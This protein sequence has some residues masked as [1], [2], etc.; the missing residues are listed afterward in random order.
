M[1]LPF[2][3]WSD[4]YE[5]TEKN[6]VKT[7]HAFQQEN[8][9]FMK[10]VSESGTR[11][12]IDRKEK[13][14]QKSYEAN[15]PIQTI[16]IPSHGPSKVLVEFNTVN[17]E[18]FRWK[19][20]KGG[21]WVHANGID[22][23]E[24]I[25]SS[26]AYTSDSSE[27]YDYKLH[28]RNP[29]RSWTHSHGG[30][31]YV[32]IKGDLVYF[33]EEDRHLQYTRLVALSL[34]D[35]THRKVIYEETNPSVQLTLMKGENRCLFFMRENAGYQEVGVIEETTCHWFKK[36]VYYFPVGYLGSV[37]VFFSRT[38]GLDSPWNL[39]GVDWILNSEICSGG[40]EFCST[41]LRLLVSR[42]YGVRTIW[43][44]SSKKEPKLLL[45]GIMEIF[46]Y[47]R[48]PFWR[49]EGMLGQPLWVREPT[50]ELYPILCNSEFIE[51]QRPRKSYAYKRIGSTRSTDGIPVRWVLLKENET[52]KP[53]G[54]LMIAYG[55]YGLRTSLNTVRWIPW[56]RAGWAIALVFV[57]GGGD[58][59]EMWAQ[60]GRLSGKVQA[61]ED[62]EEC[63]KDLQVLTGC[64]PQKT[65]IFGRSA[66]GLLIGN[67]ISRNP[68]GILFKHVYAEVPYVDLLKTASNRRLP[69]TQYEYD[70][71]G[72]PAR[73]P[74]DFEL[75]MNLSPI[76][77][78]SPRGAP[79]INVLCRSGK[80]D[81]QVFPYESLKWIYSL[82]GFNSNDTTKILYVNNQSHYTYG[83]ERHKDLAEDF[84]IINKWLI[85]RDE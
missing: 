7:R 1:S 65:C 74:L 29:Q 33:L 51:I 10:T 17:E 26:V 24:D 67:L 81:I 71:F 69:L 34:A 46:S 48:W 73:S 44:L 36:G 53:M 22:V 61:I 76:H 8:K 64:G 42:T 21:S 31:P 38:K 56:L 27:P 41:S 11:A 66:G 20:E 54:L 58:G 84:L 47:T 77:T 68:S 75:V 30:G 55:A 45:R 6:T 50:M 25:P 14:Y 9:L 80:N 16:L 63:C 40:I 28:I 43:R 3:Q 82:R 5:W 13:E 4:P 37:P 52:T 35:G 85:S 32:A 39:F 60:L 19:Y 49:G 59:N 2:L 18:V 15:H 83:K 70:E 72:N 23:S 12:A 62:L 79:G 78:L 57:R